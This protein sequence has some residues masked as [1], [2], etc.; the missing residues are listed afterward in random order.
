MCILPRW[1]ISLVYCSFGAVFGVMPLSGAQ[2]LQ[3]GPEQV[4]LL[5]LYTSQ[6]CS[7]CP[8]AERWISRWE[9][10]PELW[11]RIVPV[12]FHVDYWDRLGWEDPFAQPEFSARQRRYAS[13]L[14]L[15]SVYTPGFFENGEEWR[16]FF[17]RQ[18]S[19]LL[20][21]TRPGNLSVVLA[22]GS[23]SVSFDGEGAGRAYVAILGFGRE[24]KVTSGENR[25]RT[26]GSAFTVQ[27]LYAAPLGADGQAELQLDESRWKTAT[28]R[29]AI[30]VWVSPPD[31]IG[32][33][34]A[35]GGWLE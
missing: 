12:V 2:H 34:Q 23:V 5:E 7:S 9:A 1:F 10:R 13:E 14:G 29:H 33:I 11:H 28:Q 22:D 26:L 3:S 19:D 27:A 31:S 6:G 16:G 30:A 35:T 8:P 15:R 17:S 21:R 4:L 25:G 32:P 20:S 24:T 18:E